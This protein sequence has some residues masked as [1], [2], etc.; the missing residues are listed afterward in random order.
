MMSVL[1]ATLLPTATLLS[2]NPVRWWGCCI[3]CCM[4]GDGGVSR[5]APLLS[6]AKGVLAEYF[7][8]IRCAAAGAG[9]GQQPQ[10]KA[11]QLHVS[12]R[13]DATRVRWAASTLHVP[14]C[15]R[16]VGDAAAAAAA[17]AACLPALEAGQ[18]QQQGWPPCGP[19]FATDWGADAV[20]KVGMLHAAA[21]CRS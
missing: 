1:M 15:R 2:A 14:L 5:R 18:Q 21:A 17:S 13:Q 11:R 7:S 10:Q 8:L 6:M 12:A 4:Q 20:A 9:T 3:C 19:A 16:V